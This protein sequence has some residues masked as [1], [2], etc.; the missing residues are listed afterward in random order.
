MP[1][2][3][4]VKFRPVAE[5]LRGSWY[6]RVLGPKITDPRLWGVNRRA[7]TTAFGA[8]VAICFIPVPPHLIIGLV[9]AMIW[10]LNVPTMVGTLLLFNLFTAPL[11]YLIAYKVGALLLHHRA[12][13][14]FHFEVSWAWLQSGLGATWKP[15]LL[16]CLVCSVVCGYLAYRAL[17]LLLRNNLR[18]RWRKRR[19]KAPPV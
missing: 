13:P 15:F 16:G 5:K 8:A 3:L 18:T 7:I 10:H 6:F 9:A 17:E 14:K 12:S 19:D 1:R 2:Q 4:F 11:F